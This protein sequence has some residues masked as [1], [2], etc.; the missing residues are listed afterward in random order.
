VQ[1]QLPARVLALA[2]AAVLPL[3]AESFEGLGPGLGPPP[4]VE[5]GRPAPT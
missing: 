2:P 4:G 1:V 5:G 3:A